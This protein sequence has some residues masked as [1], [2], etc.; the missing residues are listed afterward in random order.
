MTD[1]WQCRRS[2]HR[3]RGLFSCDVGTVHRLCCFGCLCRQQ[4]WI[5]C[6]GRARPCSVRIVLRIACLSKAQCD[7]NAS[8]PILLTLS[9]Y[10]LLYSGT[11]SSLF[12]GGRNCFRYRHSACHWFSLQGL[13]HY[14]CPLQ[15]EPGLQ[16]RGNQVRK[17]LYVP[18][19]DQV[20]QWCFREYYTYLD[21]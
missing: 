4:V 2:K 14:R 15:D 7:Q 19:V 17:S 12:V 1:S 8:F 10:F 21:H 9:L 16:D 5:R 20:V 18:A 6:L 11:Q 3:V 13:L